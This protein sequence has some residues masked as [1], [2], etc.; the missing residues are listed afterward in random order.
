ME[1]NKINLKISFNSPV[2]LTF[3]I[4]CLA[5]L[6][7]GI[8]TGDRSTLRLFSVYRAPFSDPLTYFR[9]FGHVFGHAGW[10]HF[11]GNITMLL[12]VGPMLEEKYGSKNILFVILA[13]ALITGIVHFIFSPHTALLG[14]S[15]VVFAFILLSSFT[16]IREG[17]IPLTFILVVLIY[18]GGQIYDGI[19]VKD[20][21]SNLTHIIG[22]GVGSG[23]GYVMAKNKM[24]NYH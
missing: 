7:L 9:F 15:G 3:S 10:D 1:K 14:A 5:A 24:D 23:L 11:I 19:F 17:K 13:T 8:V 22:G 12:V 2:V 18:I 4:I 21:V 16:S 20:N 6:I